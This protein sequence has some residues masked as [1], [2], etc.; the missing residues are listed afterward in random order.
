MANTHVYS[1]KEEIA[2]AITHGL[3]TLLSIAGLVLLIVFA[4]LKGTA[5]HVV[6]FT[7]FGVT[8]LLLYTASTLVHSFPEGKVKDLFETF[9]HSCIYLFIAGTYTP[10][11]LVTLRSPL[12]WTLFGIVWGLAVA[13]VVFKAFFT[14]KFLVLSTLFYVMMGW[15]IVFA[16]HPLQA[17]LMPGGIR[18]LIIG[19]LL[20]TV[21][22][23]FYIWRGFPYHHAV[24]HLFVVAGSVMHFFAI[25]LYVL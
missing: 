9:D 25:L 15:L 18:L 19:G 16:W 20:Y 24:W 7:I 1:R 12:G 6:S 5:W 8:M 2:N 11:L 17:L 4:S 21:G 23:M 13:G 22:S 3:G 14:K 10:I